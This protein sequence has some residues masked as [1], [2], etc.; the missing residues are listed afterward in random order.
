[1]S[2]LIVPDVS[3]PRLANS[4]FTKAPSSASSDWGIESG[5]SSLLPPPA[6]RPSSRSLAPTATERRQW[7]PVPQLHLGFGG[8]PEH[9]ASESASPAV[10]SLSSPRSPRSPSLTSVQ[11]VLTYTPWPPQ[12]RTQVEQRLTDVTLDVVTKT[13]PWTPAM[14][15]SGALD[16]YGSEQEP[17]VGSRS[18]SFE[19]P[20]PRAIEAMSLQ[21]SR[22]KPAVATP[23]QRQV[24]GPPGRSSTASRHSADNL[25]EARPISSLSAQSEWWHDSIILGRLSALALKYFA[26]K[27]TRLPWQAWQA[28]LAQGREKRLKE[29]QSRQCVAL[30]GWRWRTIRRGSRLRCKIPLIR[31]ICGI[32]ASA[33]RPAWQ[34]L[35][36]AVFLQRELRRRL[37]LL[38]LVK[39]K[40]LDSV[41]RTHYF[42]SL[43][44]RGFAGLWMAQL[45]AKAAAES[46]GPERPWEPS[47]QGTRDALQ[48]R[49]PLRPVQQ[50]LQRAWRRWSHATQ[51]WLSSAEYNLRETEAWLA[52]E[53]STPRS[54]ALSIARREVDVHRT[55]AKL[56]ERQHRYEAAVVRAADAGATSPGRNEAE[57]MS[58][59]A[60]D[61]PEESDDLG[62][63]WALR[64]QLACKAVT[65]PVMLGQRG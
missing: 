33:L 65:R 21:P 31:A 37:L 18:R 20:H 10:S 41:A 34:H 48:E 36:Q 1:M 25:G 3:I 61:K 50:V 27:A 15:R 2:R 5:R 22:D 8:F 55:S 51:M 13:V 23:G 53:C 19:A 52:G 7:C 6:P 26:A 9:L 30:R 24:A 54:I 49:E 43:L 38:Q 45:R 39:R 17:A 11:S 28:R 46:L 32:P 64:G 56:S 57:S 60:I 12:V 16:R 44:Q 58:Q 42:Q 62:G 35:K 59:L 14:G 4:H 63:Y 40:A 47:R 29:I